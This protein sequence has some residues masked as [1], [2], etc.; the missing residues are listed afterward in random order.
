[1]RP[2]RAFRRGLELLGAI[3][4]LAMVEAAEAPVAAPAPGSKPASPLPAQVTEA[5]AARL[6]KF[7]PPA[8]RPPPSAPRPEAANG[9]ELPGDIFSLPTITVTTGKPPPA[10][11]FDWL[12]KKGRLDLALKTHRGLSFGPLARLNNPVAVEMQKEE[13]EA[14]KRAALKEQV[15]SVAVGDK[16][17]AK[18]L[19]RLMEAATAR[20][21]TDW[22]TKAP[23]SR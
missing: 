16:A 4:W 20:P 17:K 14:G 15:Q 7:V 21:N 22:Q 1:M 10:T 19:L 9:G 8:L 13:L 18:E 23:G 5:V 6:P 12:T 2:S 11:E 3:S